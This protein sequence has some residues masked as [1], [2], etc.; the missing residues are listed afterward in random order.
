MR[1]VRNLVGSLILVSL[2]LVVV[3]VGGSLLGRQTWLAGTH[4]PAH[5]LVY[6]LQGGAVVFWCLFLAAFFLLRQWIRQHEQQR[7]ARFQHALHESFL[8][9]C[10]EV[11]DSERHRASEVFGAPVEQV[12]ALLEHSADG[13]ALL[14][15]DGTLQYLTPSAP[16]ILGFVPA[17]LRQ[18]PVLERVH[19]QDRRAFR[20]LLEQCLD[21][22]RQERRATLRFQRKD[23]AWLNLEWIGAGWLHEPAVQGIVVSFR[24]AAHR[25]QFPSL[26]ETERRCLEEQLWQA[27][28][29]ENLAQ[30]AAGA[31]HELNNM[32]TVIKGHGDLMSEQI[33]P[34]H[35]L[36]VNVEVVQCAAQRTVNLIRRM[37]DLSRPQETEAKIIDLND[38]VAEIEQV[39]GPVMG[40]RIQV[41]TELEPGLG[42]IKADPDQIKQIILNL[43][44]NA[45][46]A[47][48]AGGQLTI[49]TANVDLGKTYARIHPDVQPGPH[50]MLVVSDTGCGMSDEVQSHLFEPLFSTKAPGKGSG[51]GL[52]TVSGIVKQSNGHIKVFSL[53]GQG[54]T[55]RI[56]LPRVEKVVHS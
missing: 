34:G 24:P 39:L 30:L 36:R 44:L 8:Q 2:G 13:L 56:Y 25:D 17:E 7:S 31:A 55:F 49:E 38:L 41:V 52:S 26:S 1:P 45:R 4:L 28:K 15:G 5:Y 18:R 3:I 40:G 9:R 20:E 42:H 51:L 6:C 16:R 37:L 46:D 50:V 48:S 14:S 33:P 22:P 47:M 32:A 23:G 54:A 10:Q 27:Q 29:M 11:A 43:A 35:P 53:P 12:Q 21:Q 19:P